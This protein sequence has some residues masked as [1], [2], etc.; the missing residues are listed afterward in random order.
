MIQSHKHKRHGVLRGLP[1][2]NQ[3]RGKG[4]GESTHILPAE[5]TLPLFLPSQSHLTN[6]SKL[7]RLL[8]WGNFPL[9]PLFCQVNTAYENQV[10]VCILTT[11]SLR[12]IILESELVSVIWLH[13]TM[14]YEPENKTAS[15]SKKANGTFW[16]RRSYETCFDWETETNMT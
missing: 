15:F 7:S 6:V 16:A 4:S 13:L 14:I 11:S 12:Q 2:R 3:W 5:D 1:A 10:V 8:S 9:Q